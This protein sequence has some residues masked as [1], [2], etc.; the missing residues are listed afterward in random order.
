LNP[1]DL[2]SM[3]GRA[4]VLQVLSVIEH[5]R[6]ITGWAAREGVMSD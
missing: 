2:A 4:G 6:A 3:D 1:S 5:E